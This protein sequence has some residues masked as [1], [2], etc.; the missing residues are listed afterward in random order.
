[1][2]PGG[3]SS[4]PSYVASGHRVTRIPGSVCGILGQGTS[5]LVNEDISRRCSGP[6]GRDLASD[7][8]DQEATITGDDMVAERGI[9]R[10][11]DA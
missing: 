1:M 6:S 5:L 3:V 11:R 8:S 4:D 7:I 2:H 9:E 10:D